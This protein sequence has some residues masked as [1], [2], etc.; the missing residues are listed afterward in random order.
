MKTTNNNFDQKEK[1]VTLR[2]TETQI[3]GAVSRYI[4][5]WGFMSD[6][7]LLWFITNVTHPV[8]MSTNVTKWASFGREWHM[9][10]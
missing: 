2:R 8:I 5:L 1:H 4:Q 9:I 6:I 7:V 3:E 10:I